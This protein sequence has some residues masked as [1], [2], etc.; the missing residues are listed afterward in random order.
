MLRFIVG[1][2]IVL[3]GLVH[4]LYLGQS[5]RLF[6]LQAGMVWPDG[7]WAFS[8]L[9]KDEVIRG[10]ASISCLL[11]A[12]GF[13][14]GGT[15]IFVGQAWWH[16]VVVGSATFSVIIFIL[17]WDGKMQHL[18][19]KGGIGI[20]INLAILVAGLILRWPDFEF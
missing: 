5:K 19:D 11:A 10:L 4:L 3:H 18:D 2:F 17:F 15:G 14:A 7:S 6:E 20:L 9:F 13:V 1:I 16:P 12:I 8:K